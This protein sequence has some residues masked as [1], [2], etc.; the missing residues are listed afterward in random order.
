MKK[1]NITIGLVLI[2]AA[3]IMMGSAMGLIPDIPWI[4]ILCSV[5][6]AGWGI[7]AIMER[8]FFGMFMS[9]SI[10]AWLFD[11]ELG[12]DNLAPFP[13]LIAAACLGIG[14]NMIFGKKKKEVNIEYSADG[15][16]NE[17]WTDGRHVTLEN[18][19]NSTS[20]YVNA[21]A[22]S[23]AKLE[24]NFGSANVYFNNAN[25][26]NG[27]ATIELDNSFGKMNIYLPSKW[28]AS[29]SQESAFGH[30]NIHGEPNRDMD[31]PYVIIKAESNFGELNIFF[32]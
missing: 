22:F 8:D 9:V 31:A 4:R 26:Y 25:V 27:E 5:L 2:V 24:N 29:I 32:E 7:R 28:R 3:I 10:I 19:F 12:I 30:V 11:D 16:G 13:L 21:A 14:L 20:K 18:N 6:L 23:S 1:N 15:V 17:T